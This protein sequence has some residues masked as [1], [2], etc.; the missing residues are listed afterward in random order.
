MPDIK[1]LDLDMYNDAGS[2]SKHN[3]EPFQT[4]LDTT[5]VGSGEK[6]FTGQSNAAL[7]GEQR[8]SDF[9][10]GVAAQ[11][12][13]SVTH[14]TLENIGYLFDLENWV[15]GVSQAEGDYSNWWSERAKAAQ[16]EVKQ[17]FPVEL[18]ADA[19]GY[20]PHKAEWWVANAPSFASGAAMFLPSTMTVKALST[21]GKLSKVGSIA[22][23]VA[24]GEKA[25]ETL[26]KG[27]RML[28]KAG[29][30]AS[31]NRA[32]IEGIT[33][34]LTSRYLEN[35]QSAA[36]MFST[37]YEEG[38]A[39]GLS[40][41]DAKKKAGRAASNTWGAGWIMAMTDIPQFIGM[42]KGTRALKELKQSKLGMLKDIAKDALSEAAEEGIQYAIGAEAA[43]SE[44]IL[45]VFSNISKNYGS[46]LEDDEFKSS[47][48]LGAAGGGL[49]ATMGQV[50]NN[51]I[52]NESIKEQAF[53][54]GLF[55]EVARRNFYPLM[56]ILE[57]D[58]HEKVREE[59]KRQKEAGNPDTELIGMLEQYT[60]FHEQLSRATKDKAVIRKSMMGRFTEDMIS[61]LEGE[62]GAL[63]G[64]LTPQ[65]IA[66][67]KK[68]ILENKVKAPTE[69]TTSVLERYNKELEGYVSTPLD[70]PEMPLLK[71]KLSELVKLEIE[72]GKY[73]ATARP[74]ATR[75]NQ[76]QNTNTPN[77]NT[78]Q[79]SPPTDENIP[80][81]DDLLN[82]NDIQME[83]F[84]TQE[85]IIPEIIPPD[86]EMVAA[87]INNRAAYTEPEQVVEPV[88]APSSKSL[89][90]LPDFNTDSVSEGSASGY[91]TI[92][93][94]YLL[95]G[96]VDSM[97]STDYLAQAFSGVFTKAGAKIEAIR[98]KYIK[99]VGNLGNIKDVVNTEMYNNLISEIRE[100]V[101]SSYDSK[102]AEQL[103]DTILKYPTGLPNRLGNEVSM[104]L[105]ELHNKETTSN[106]TEQSGTPEIG[107]VPLEDLYDEVQIV[108][109]EV[110]TT[111]DAA[112]FE[113]EVNRVEEDMILS[114]IPAE[115]V[116]IFGYERIK[117]G[118]DVLAHLSRDYETVIEVGDNGETTIKRTDVNNELNKNS[119]H[120]ILDFSKYPV[121][122]EV[123]FELLDDD[124]MNVY[125]PG[126]KETTT[127]GALKT[128]VDYNE[129]VPI[130]VKDADGNTLGY[131][132]SSDWMQDGNIYGDIAENKKRV[133]ELRAAVIANG[134]IT[135]KISKRTKGKLFKSKESVTVDK[136]H[137]D[138]ELTVWNGTKYT[139]NVKGK[140]ILNK[141][142]GTGHIYSVVQV[143][144]DAYIGIP[145]RTGKLQ[146]QHIN[147]LMSAIVI[148]TSKV[149]TP[150]M[151][152][153]NEQ[154][155]S[156]GFDM[157][158]GKQFEAYFNTFL[159]NRSVP[160]AFQRNYSKPFKSGLHAWAA[161]MMGDPLQPKLVTSDK[162]HF[163]IGDGNV[164][165]T[166]G[167]V[168]VSLARNR[169]ASQAELNKLE[170][171]LKKAYLNVNSSKIG[172][173]IKIPLLN[174]DGTVT[175]K[176]G[177]YSDFVKENST[178][179]VLTAKVG[180]R[181]V[182][183]IQPV[184]T[185]DTSFL[186]PEAVNAVHPE[187]KAE[188]TKTVSE[189][190]KE[191]VKK[192]SKFG[193][194]TIDLTNDESFLPKVNPDMVR[195]KLKIVQ[196]LE[197]IPRGTFSEAKLQ[198]WLNDLTKQGV[199]KQQLDIFRDYAKD[200]MTKDE[201]ITSIAA[202]L[203]FVVE[204]SIT[205]G[206]REENDNGFDMMADTMPDDIVSQ[207]RN[208]KPTSYYS[209]LTVAGGTNYTENEI[210]TP[211]II[212]SI[213]GHASF[214]TDFGVGWHRADEQVLN[215]ELLL[216]NGTVK[217]IDC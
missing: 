199:S 141:E 31:K 3:E 51:L 126:T 136:A 74:S 63:S 162:V 178:T 96:G 138:T 103:H 196:A 41:E 125:V 216:Q 20:S 77:P 8:T 183:N 91:G 109:D 60:D 140:K 26:T 18:S 35:T 116:Q 5:Y 16:D 118:W 148:H 40:D 76:N 179:N 207:Y 161:A 25:I 212:P 195:Y 191:E 22:A 139:D 189:G 39:A 130:V 33:A 203:S 111:L 210:K 101:V 135:S 200:G 82:D 147:S 143:S 198:G 44:N 37:V 202:D 75:N 169:P 184:V 197:N 144:D 34:G 167:D 88:I 127:W 180:D 170:A 177:T 108:E 134:K 107:M 190:I 152:A 93:A 175:T 55:S 217:Q 159:Y 168:G 155:K 209:N 17:L 176:S 173:S 30:F 205:T 14:G 154:F 10:L 49:F 211:N 86:D 160:E 83:G 24:K 156:A 19:Q 157:T 54:Q 106:A 98:Q 28:L 151:T 9:L 206:G 145:I 6:G 42:F 110:S 69:L 187:A 122:T 84:P 124:N 208:D 90:D 182:A 105:D 89:R 115:D 146:E 142:P 193:K 67:L 43:K 100:A 129:N 164:N 112:E 174:P 4:Q 123:T 29:T 36:E 1:M 99:E 94:D 53:E 104:K 59:V 27:E 163:N 62:V 213:K 11:T 204:S 52:H 121:G 48:T 68:E 185:F 114:D 85:P 201:I 188:V 158:D 120:R 132:H 150:A 113:I 117:D 81:I 61:R 186:T 32:G 194:K 172:S 192:K 149:L 153:L 46:Y 166:I 45:D 102:E 214:A 70:T 47:L 78:N 165:F 80:S 7:K 2:Q 215:F 58:G 95:T 131:I 57:K 65:D 38:K 92:A 64:N 56:N 97:L 72:R 71:S 119:D 133:A 181:Y 128:T 87:D 66:K 12:I 15:S 73:S 137:P 23:K 13:S 50:V 171:A 21:V 79:P